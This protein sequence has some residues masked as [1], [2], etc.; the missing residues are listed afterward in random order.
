MPAKVIVAPVEGDDTESIQRAIDQV[1][2]LPADE[3]G[4]RGAV[5]LESGVYEIAGQIR[6][7]VGGVVLRGRG[8]DREGGSVLVGTGRDRRSLIAVRGGSEPVFPET[9]GQVGIVNEY[10]PCGGSR[11]TLEPGH[12][13]VPGDHVRIEHPST[14]AWIAAVGMDRFPSR[15]GGS[16]L[17]WKSGTLDIAWERVISAVDGDAVTIDV[18]LPMALDAALAQ[19]TVRR[20]DW[21]ARIDHVGVE[22]LGLESAG[23]EGRPADEDHAWDG[24]SLANVRD[25]WVRDCGF[26]GFAGSAVNV[27][28]T[29]TRVTVERCSSRAP[30]SEIGGWRRRTFFVGGGQVLVR[31][32]AAEEGREDFGVGHLA[33]GPNA[34]VRCVAR[35]SHAHSGPHG[36]WATGVL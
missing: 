31:D 30:R 5:L 11:L 1:A 26:T 18:P 32:C 27:I 13:L 6:L 35:R 2:T 16:W 14:K 10:V 3:R 19:A 23:D 9:V 12:G 4:F 29:A 28:D 34:F 15:G 33:P 22:R 17:D 25:A 20:L 36:S 24:V 8:A 21:P 7:A